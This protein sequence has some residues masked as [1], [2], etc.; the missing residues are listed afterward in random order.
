MLLLVWPAHLMRAIKGKGRDLNVEF[1]PIVSFHPIFSHHKTRRCPKH[2]TAGILIRIAM[3]QHWLLAN[4]TGA[5]HFLHPA[6]TVGDVPIA[7]NKLHGLFTK[8]FELDV[9][10]PNI[11]VHL[12]IGLLLKIE[13][14]NRNFD[15]V[16]G[17]CVHKNSQ[18]GEVLKWGTFSK[19][20]NS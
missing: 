7:G 18:P 1:F 11:V 2:R 9:I 4:D 8:I 19:L 14:H 5:V 17:A 13:G 3:T 15:I 10:S 12:G 20:K 6:I 16:S